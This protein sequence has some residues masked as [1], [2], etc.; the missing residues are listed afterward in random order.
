MGMRIAPAPPP[1]VQDIEEMLDPAEIRGR[2]ADCQ[3][4]ASILRGLL[5]V[6]LRAQRA[7]EH[8]IHA[9]MQTATQPSR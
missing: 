3:R 5:R 9:T 4:Q 8:Q 7:R 6:A 2:L 1:Q